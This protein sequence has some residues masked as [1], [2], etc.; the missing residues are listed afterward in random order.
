MDPQKR[1]KEKGERRKKKATL[2]L[3]LVLVFLETTG[4]ISS[5]LQSST[6]NGSNSVT[7]NKMRRAGGLCPIRSQVGEYRSYN[8]KTGRSR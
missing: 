2:D 7:T 4:S 3:E 6:S 5:N 1:R 8:Q